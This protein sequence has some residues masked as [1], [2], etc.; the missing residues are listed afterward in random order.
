MRNSI[1]LFLAIFIGTTMTGSQSA[2]D[3]PAADRG[4][5]SDRLYTNQSLGISWELPDGWSVDNNQPPSDENNQVLLRLLPS[6]KESNE[7]VELRYSADDSDTIVSGLRSKGWEPIGKAGSLS[8]GGGIFFSR[9]DFTLTGSPSTYL[10]VFLGQRRN[11]RLLWSLVAA[12]PER[13][14]QLVTAVRQIR[15]QPDWGNAEGPFVPTAPGSLPNTVR[16]SQGVTQSLSQTK[17]QPIYPKEA[18]KAHIQGTVLLLAHIS[19]EGKIKNIYV[20]S[21]HPFLTQSAIEAVSRWTYRPYLLQG[22]P[23]EIETQ[24]TVNFNLQ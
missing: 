11:K 21:G 8:L 10:T 12:S 3:N 22:K 13:L 17:I 2:T 23:V 16:V 7:F 24:I 14:N 19:T 6:G 1:L 20:L 9:T 4:L 15:V 5:L 18:R